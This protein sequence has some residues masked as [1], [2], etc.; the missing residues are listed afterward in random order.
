MANPA[1]RL[2]IGSPPQYHHFPPSHNATHFSEPIPQPDWEGLIL[3]SDPPGTVWEA[4]LGE[5]VG[6]RSLKGEWW[7]SALI[8]LLIPSLLLGVPL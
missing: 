7:H 5:E 6:N 4:L 8:V 3:P 2:L 1:P